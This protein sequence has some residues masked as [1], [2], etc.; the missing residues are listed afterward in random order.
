MSTQMKHWGEQLHAGERVVWEVQNS[1]GEGTLF[2]EMDD[3][4][5]EVTDLLDQALSDWAEPMKF[6]WNVMVR[7]WAVVKE[8]W[9]AFQLELAMAVAPDEVPYEGRLRSLEDTAAAHD[10]KGGAT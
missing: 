8:E 6:R 2:G 9:S 1:V 3:A 4:V 7:P 10:A 5:E